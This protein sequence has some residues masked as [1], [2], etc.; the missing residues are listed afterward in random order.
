M[1]HFRTSATTLEPDSHTLC[2]SQSFTRPGG[3]PTIMIPMVG[4]RRPADDGV[5]QYLQDAADF[6]GITMPSPTDV[7]TALAECTAPQLVA[8]TITITGDGVAVVSTTDVQPLSRDAVRIVGDESVPQA[9]RAVDPWWRRM[10][11]RT[12]SRG[13]LDQRERWLNGRGYAD[14]MSDGW[15]L[16]GA[17]L[18]E[19]PDGI[20]GVE[21]PEPTSVLDQL[22][23]CEVIAPIAQGSTLPTDAQRVWWISPRYQTHPVAELAGTRFSVD[24]EAVPP[25]ARWS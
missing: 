16:L 19:T 25:F 20:V 8:V 10:A 7:T 13:E 3:L 15:P 17:L 4:A 12:T 2:A 6:F 9:H 18:F 1:T 22:T 5:W 11:S 21:N 23:Q 14:G 24:D